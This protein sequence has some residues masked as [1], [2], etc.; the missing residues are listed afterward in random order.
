[1]NGESVEQ[2][3]NSNIHQHA[4]RRAVALAF[5]G[6]SAAYDI[7]LTIS[8]WPC[9]NPRGD[10]G[11]HQWLQGCAMEEGITITV[12]V[13]GDQGGYSATHGLDADSTG[14]LTYHPDGRVT[15]V[16]D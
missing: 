6:K 8:A 11:C 1:V 15:T 10:D 2:G 5:P 13:T 14:T 16:L 7:R 9:S 3:S 4:E 12:V